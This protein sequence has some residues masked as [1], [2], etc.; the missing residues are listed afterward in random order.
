MEKQTYTTWRDTVFFKDG[1]GRFKYNK[2][3]VGC[4]RKCKQ[5]FRVTV[6]S[7]PHYCPARKH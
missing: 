3:C 4:T 2:L 6:V 5:S 7:C 1:S